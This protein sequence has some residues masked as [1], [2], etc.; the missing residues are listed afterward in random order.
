MHSTTCARC[1]E[2]DSTWQK[3]RLIAHHFA[4][5]VPPNTDRKDINKHIKVKIDILWQGDPIACVKTFGT[6]ACKLCA[7][8]RLNI[9]KASLKEP[10]NCINCCNEIYGACHHKPKFHGFEAKQ[11]ASADESGMDKRVVSQNTN[12]NDNAVLPSD[13]SEDNDRREA[14]TLPN[15]FHIHKVTQE[16]ENAL[17]SF[18]TRLNQLALPTHGTDS[19]NEVP[20]E[21]KDNHPHEELPFLYRPVQSNKKLNWHSPQE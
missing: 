11:I 3:I 10:T 9:L 2:P 21:C 1:E 19:A 14:H 5:L 8:E 17:A 18:R 20:Q 4:K 13:N 15:E 16:R 6:R 7:K 12:G